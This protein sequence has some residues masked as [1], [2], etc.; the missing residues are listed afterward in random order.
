MGRIGECS[1]TYSDRFESV[2]ELVKIAGSI[3][4]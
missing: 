1:S 4:R 2:D 3:C